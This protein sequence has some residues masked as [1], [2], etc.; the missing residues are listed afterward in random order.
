MCWLDRED[1]VVDSIY[2]E[3]LR[4]DCYWLWTWY[5]F[6]SMKHGYGHCTR[7]DTLTPLIIWENHIIKCNYGSVSCW[8][9]TWHVSDTRVVLHRFVLTEL[10]ISCCVLFCVC[11]WIL[12]IHWGMVIGIWALITLY[13]L[14]CLLC[15]FVCC[16]FGFDSYSLLFVHMVV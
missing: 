11:G 15:P 16:F 2:E 6:V 7:H 12:R 9:R 4:D 8:C 3:M 10:A 1:R 5:W 13:P 14:H